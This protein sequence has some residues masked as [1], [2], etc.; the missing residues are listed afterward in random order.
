MWNY[1]RDK[2]GVLGLLPPEKRLIY[3]LPSLFSLFVLAGALIS[4]YFWHDYMILGYIYLALMLFYFIII[5]A[6]SL[7]R[8][9]KRFF[10]IFPGIFLT[11]MTYGLG[12]TYGLLKKKRS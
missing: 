1:G 6:E 5:G 8:N 7:R 4:V 10:L 9:P 2:A 11:H 3:F 12:F